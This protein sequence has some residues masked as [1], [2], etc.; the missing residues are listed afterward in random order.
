M[1]LRDFE[2]LVGWAKAQGWKS[3]RLL[4]G[5]P[6]V[7]PKFEAILNVAERHGFTVSFS[8]NGLFAPAL[9]ASLKK[10][11]IES[12][13]FSYPQDNLPAADLK[14]FHANIA[15]AVGKKIPVVLSW[16]LSPDNE[17]WEKI[18]NL[19]KKFRDSVIVRF[20]MVLPGHQRNFDVKE[21]RDHI[22]GMARQIL[23]IARYAYKNY[24]VF[25]FYRPLLLCMFTKE[26]FAFL[27][28]ISRNLFDS[29]CSC[30]CVEGTMITV[31][32]DL[33]CSPCPS[34]TSKGL[35]I[36][37]HIK[38]EAITLNFKSAL[39]A[40]SARPLMDSCKTCRFFANYKLFLE[41]RSKN[42][43][44]DELCNGGCYQYR[45]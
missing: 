9:N 6:T 40:L 24:V 19:A 37:S 26:Q 42:F 38:R 14:I 34:L 13:N 31:N 44:N 11:L 39:K 35:K 5:E 32:P 27:R 36:T 17:E 25:Y 21:F 41:D 30:S 18:V 29:F 16:V 15:A 45:A 33:T 43:S 1:S 7:H 23:C 3:L 12:V 2:F 10:G 28:S 8:T 20:S 4:G 22:Q